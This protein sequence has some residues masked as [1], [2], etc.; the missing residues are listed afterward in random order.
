MSKQAKASFE[1][2][3]WEEKP[4][5]VIEGELKLTQASVI[6]TYAGEIQGEAKVEYLMVYREDGSASF[7]G[8]ERVI[9]S[10]SGRSGSFVLQ[11]NGTFEEGIAKYSFSVVPGSGTRDLAGLRGKG[12]F[13]S[14]HQQHYPLTL[15]YDFE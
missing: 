2:T 3:G 12:V 14:G 6:R 5:N 15:S 11:H 8:I 7:V 4:Y 10:L 9:G 13:A 1:I